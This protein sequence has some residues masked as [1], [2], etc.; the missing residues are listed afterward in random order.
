MSVFFTVSTMT[1]KE[2]TYGKLKVY[3]RQR[4]ND[5]LTLLKFHE[6]FVLWPE[7]DFQVV[8]QEKAFCAVSFLVSTTIILTHV[9]PLSL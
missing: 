4:V 9:T 7:K 5:V 6:C 2:L 1:H 8:R 3:E